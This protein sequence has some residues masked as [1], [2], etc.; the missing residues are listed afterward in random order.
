MRT[1]KDQEQEEILKRRTLVGLGYS[2]EKANL[3]N[4]WGF[5][6]NQGQKGSKK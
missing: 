6:P 1:R 5:S 3:C 2:F 4:I